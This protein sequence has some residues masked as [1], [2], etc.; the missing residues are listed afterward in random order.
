MGHRVADFSQPSEAPAGLRRIVLAQEP[1]EVG[2][3]TT[4]QGCNVNGQLADKDLVEDDPERIDVGS[5]V[6]VKWQGLLRAH[7]DGG[8]EHL[9]GLGHEDISGTLMHLLGDAK[10]DD[11]RDGLTALFDHEDVGRLQVPVNDASLVSMVNTVEHLAKKSQPLGHAQR[12]K[13]AVGSYRGAPH[14]FHDNIGTAIRGGPRVVKLSNVAMLQP[15]EH[16]ALRGETGDDLI[17]FY[18]PPD[19]LDGHLP[20]NRP[21]LRGAVDRAHA[22]LT[23]PPENP[24][25]AKVL[26]VAGNPFRLRR[27]RALPAAV[28]EER[29]NPCVTK[30]QVVAAHSLLAGVATE[31]RATMEMARDP[32]PA[33][34]RCLGRL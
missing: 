33:G 28:A 23:E 21:R 4:P 31:V 34:R 10:V 11:L 16:L 3:T 1:L 17:A 22:P 9:S 29:R 30:A 8:A 13:V 5:R 15:R 2:E 25:A 14:Q 18:A 6:E 32:I 12:V 20:A 24:V 26:R 27:P 7:V 19:D